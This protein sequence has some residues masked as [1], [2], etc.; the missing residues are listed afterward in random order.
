[1]GEMKIP[2]IPYK[3]ALEAYL[4]SLSNNVSPSF[5]VLYG[6]MA[7][8]DFGV[9]SDVDI[10][11]VAEDFPAKLDD[12]LQLLFNINPTTA[13]LEPIGYTPKEFEELL[14]KRHATAL[15]AMEEGILL[16]DDGTYLKMKK[17]YEKLKA[18][19]KIVKGKSGWYA[20]KIITECLRQ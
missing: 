12:R 14:R 16:H 13:P 4:K 19:L 17:M 15:F 20:E 9:G 8:G 10:L 1:M 11:V 7:R 2:N 6:S 5:V 18:D 3:N